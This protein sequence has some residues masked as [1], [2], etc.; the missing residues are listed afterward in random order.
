MQLKDVLQRQVPITDVV[1]KA[2]SGVDVV[3][4]NNTLAEEEIP[5]SGMPGREVL[6]KKAIALFFVW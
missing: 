4:S 2:S 1:V 5:I 6:Q 3:P